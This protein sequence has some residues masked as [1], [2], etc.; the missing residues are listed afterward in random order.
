M[1]YQLAQKVERIPPW[2]VASR[3]QSAAP[4]QAHM[5]ASPRGLREATC[6]W[7]IA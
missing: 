7:F 2:R 5:A 3:Y 4:S 1:S 6:H